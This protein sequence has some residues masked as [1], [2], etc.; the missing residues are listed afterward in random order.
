MF[1][2]ERLRTC[3]IYEHDTRFNHHAW[4]HWNYEKL[5]ITL[6]T[7]WWDRGKRSRPWN[8]LIVVSD[9]CRIFDVP[10]THPAKT[11]ATT[12]WRHQLA[13]TSQ[14]ITWPPLMTSEPRTSGAQRQTVNH[15][16]PSWR[17]WPVS[18]R[19]TWPP[20]TQAWVFRSLGYPS[21]RRRR[22][23][24]YALPPLVRTTL[25]RPWD[26]KI[27]VT[28]SSQGRRGALEAG[29]WRTVAASRTWKRC[30]TRWRRV[31]ARPGI[32]WKHWTRRTA[33]D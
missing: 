22:R 21:R 10:M 7:L 28:T 2:L 32:G 6:Q 16:R 25:P 3:M 27:K 9:A 30:W 29:R 14:Q 26:N 31:N 15:S 20:L 4:L 1:C 18:P 13:V 33:S 12:A 19:V 8:K 11:A 5:V 17:H 23:L 24:F